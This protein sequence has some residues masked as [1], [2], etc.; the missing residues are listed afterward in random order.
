MLSAGGYD[1]VAHLDAGVVLQPGEA[2]WAHAQARLATWETQA[3]QTGRSRVR[4]GGR[5]VDSPA[6]GVTVSGWRCHGEI[7]WL[8]TS[9]R[10]IGIAGNEGTTCPLVPCM[11]LLPGRDRSS[12]PGEAALMRNSVV[13][14]QGG[15][16]AGAPMSPTYPDVSPSTPPG[17]RSR[18]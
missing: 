17:P 12:R 13:Y 4:W 10:V 9:L 11:D 6:R 2:P 3:A 18:P 5:R 15:T 7:D 1:P 14:E 16:P 8:I